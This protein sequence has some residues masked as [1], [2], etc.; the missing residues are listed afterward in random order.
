[1]K[2]VYVCG[3][4]RFIGKMEELES[5]LKREGVECLMSKKARPSGISG[6]L[7]NIEKSDIVYVVNPGGYVGKSVCVD[8]GYAYARNK[9]IYVM[10]SVKDPP[11]MTLTHGVLSSAEL[12][13]LCGK[14]PGH[15]DGDRT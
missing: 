8:V 14:N 9:P 2:R 1:M 11:V 4:F 5:K 3:S 6:C 13:I 15:L 10:H 7:K 12:I